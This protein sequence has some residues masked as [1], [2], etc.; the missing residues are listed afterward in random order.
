MV[1]LLRKDEYFDPALNR[2][3]VR[4]QNTTSQ[5][6][7]GVEAEAAYRDIS[8]RLGY[9][10]AALALTGRNCLGD[11]TLFGNPRLVESVDAGNC[12]FT[13][14][15]PVVLL[16][17]GGSSELLFDLLH[18]SS[19]LF[20]IGDRATQDQDTRVSSYLGWN[21]T[22]Y[23]PD[24]RGLDVTVGARNLLGREEVPAQS[25]YN[26]AR[27]GQPPLEVLKIPGPGREFYA[28]IGY[29]F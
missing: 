26:R 19:E 13:E 9:V 28:R 4:F 6:S 23:A 7:R 29:R 16:Q 12:D 1:D 21:V 18:V 11:D 8:G 20:Y 24:I 17:A 27:I 22:L 5:V 15:A 2:R 25:D 14:N 10:N 3:Q